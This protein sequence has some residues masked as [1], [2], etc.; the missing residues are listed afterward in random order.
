MSITATIEQDAG[1]SSLR[2]LEVN[3]FQPQLAI[4]P[5]TARFES[6]IVSD[7][8]VIP[9]IALPG[10]YFFGFYARSAEINIAIGFEV[11]KGVVYIL[12]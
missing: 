1:I 12:P 8:D 3:V 4:D 10:P 6:G 2:A 5:N 9:L 7:P 11:Y